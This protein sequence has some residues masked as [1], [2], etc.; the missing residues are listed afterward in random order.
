MLLVI[1]RP[2]WHV[3]AMPHT[4]LALL[5]TLMLGGAGCLGSATTAASHRVAASTTLPLADATAR[6]ALF[7]EAA[8]IRELHGLAAGGIALVAAPTV[9]VDLIDVRSDLGDALTGVLGFPSF[10][11]SPSTTHG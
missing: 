6:G 8:E 9:A 5:A 3:A 10:G 1:R 4:V 2:V 11:T 7:A